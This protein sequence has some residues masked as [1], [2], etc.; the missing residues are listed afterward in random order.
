MDWLFS[1]SNER[2][3][4]V[5]SKASLLFAA[6][7]GL[8]GLLTDYKKDGKITR[9]GKI[10]AAGIVASAVLSIAAG[11]F[12]D[13][14]EA[15]AATAAKAQR[16]LEASRFD[17][18]LGQLK[19]LNRTMSLVNRRNTTL[20]ASAQ[21]SLLAQE[22]LL[23]SQGALLSSARRSMLLTAGLT[24]QE[25]EN[26][27]RVLR[28]LWDE[29][30][31]VR[32]DTI[33]LDVTYDCGARDGTQF[34]LLLAS[35]ARAEVGLVPLTEARAAGIPFKT[36]DDR[37]ILP[38]AIVLTSVDQRVIV[39]P[40]GMLG[41][42]RRQNQ[43]SR[44][45]AFYGPDLERLAQPEQWSDLAVEVVVTALQ[46]RL[47]DEMRG[48]VGLMT[49]GGKGALQESY[50]VSSRVADPAYQV[51][52]LEACT[53]HMALLVNERTLANSKGRVVQVRENASDRRGLVVVKFFITG[54]KGEALPRYS[55]AASGR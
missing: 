49:I 38:G 6:G 50:D 9:W 44:F 29:E 27:G 24:A 47:V 42:M 32:G 36:F 2:W 16:N 37:R 43:V 39:H 22:R 20:L 5:I 28:G 54:V 19:N 55:D 1:I 13:R 46:P 26:T 41:A 40:K 51:G 25:R 35:G 34:P 21:G 30:N 18:Q 31:R 11:F 33:K 15:E 14:M 8:L 10:A 4:D 12:R 17:V 23:T 53:A 52:I 7:F 45:S 48:I 3:L